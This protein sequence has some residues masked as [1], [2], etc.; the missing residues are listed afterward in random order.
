MDKLNIEDDDLTYLI[1]LVAI[2]QRP[3]FAAL[4][5]WYRLEETTSTLV[6]QANLRTISKMINKDDETAYLHAFII[7]DTSEKLKEG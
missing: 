4:P 1:R 6:L 5:A 2:L 3:N 7:P